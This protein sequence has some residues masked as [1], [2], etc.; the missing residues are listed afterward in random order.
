MSEEKLD[1]SKKISLHFS[2]DV[3]R[4][5]YDEVAEL[6]KRTLSFIKEE[7]NLIKKDNLAR[8]KLIVAS[9]VRVSK[10]ENDYWDIQDENLKYEITEKTP[11]EYWGDFNVL[12]E[13]F[14]SDIQNYPWMPVSISDFVIPF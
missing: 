6:L 10:N 1:I 14:I 8:G 4:E 5:R 13:N 12:R 3:I 7:T 9:E 2:R 11:P